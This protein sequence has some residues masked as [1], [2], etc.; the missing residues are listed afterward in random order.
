M[1]FGTFAAFSKFHIN[2]SKSTNTKVVQFVEEHN[3]HVDWHFQILSGKGRKTWSTVSISCSPE[4]GA[5][6]SLAAD[7]AKSAEKNTLEPL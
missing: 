4:S 3:F 5:I 1:S 2:T 7:C 6:Q